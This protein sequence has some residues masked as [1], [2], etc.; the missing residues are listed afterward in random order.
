MVLWCCEA[1]GGDWGRLVVMEGD[2]AGEGRGEEGCQLG[3]S[4]FT[5]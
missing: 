4:T 1:G 3:V 5:E 2:G